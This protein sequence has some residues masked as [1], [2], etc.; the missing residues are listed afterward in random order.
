MCDLELW[1][2]RNSFCAFL[3]RVTPK[4]KCTFTGSHLR[5]VTGAD[6]NARH[7]STT[8]RETYRQGNYNTLNIKY[9]LSVW[10][11]CGLMLFISWRP[12]VHREAEQLRRLAEVAC[13]NA[14]WRWVLD[15]VE[16]KH[17]CAGYW[18]CR[19]LL[20]HGGR[21]RSLCFTL[22]FTA[23]LAGKI[24]QSVASIPSS[25][26]TNWPLKYGSWGVTW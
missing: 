8:T 5:A 17:N 20:G 7:R 4:I 2:I 1:P 9:I 12:A 22:F 19:L 15:V 23:V 24:K 10:N 18:S 14:E 11:N 21:Y 26:H 25:F 3:A 16:W 13:G 6:N